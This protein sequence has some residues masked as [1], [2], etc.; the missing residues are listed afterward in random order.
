MSALLLMARATF[1]FARTSSGITTSDIAAKTIPTILSSGA[2]R[3]IKDL[4]ES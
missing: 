1:L 2:S 3:V 4:T